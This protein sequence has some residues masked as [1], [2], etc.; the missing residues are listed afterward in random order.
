M[1]RVT[2]DDFRYLMRLLTKRAVLWTEMII[3]ETLVFSDIAME[4]HLHM[5]ET[6]EHPV[7]CQIGSSGYCL[8]WTQQAVQKV[9]ASGFDEVNL[10]AECPSTRDAIGCGARE[11]Y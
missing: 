11:K 8:E 1:I 2:D 3:D 4:H 7:I 10:N 5:D 9:V 6:V